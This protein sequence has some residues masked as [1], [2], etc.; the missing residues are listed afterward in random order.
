MR[1]FGTKDKEVWSA[2]HGGQRAC[3]DAELVK[4]ILQ[5]GAL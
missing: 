3:G 5:R 1:R 2:L 4:D